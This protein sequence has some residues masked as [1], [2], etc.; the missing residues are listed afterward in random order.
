MG[1][2]HGPV[3]YPHHHHHQSPHP[4]GGGWWG[5]AMDYGVGRGGGG[6]GYNM[7]M[8]GY[9]M[10]YSEGF[11]GGYQRPGKRQ[12]GEGQASSGPSQYPWKDMMDNWSNNGQ[13]PAP[14]TAAGEKRMEVEGGNYAARAVGGEK[15]S[16]PYRLKHPEQP[17]LNY[18]VCSNYYDHGQ[19]YCK[20]YSLSQI[21]SSIS[22][23]YI[24]R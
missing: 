21:L 23:F 2:R 14:G 9:G 12:R 3:H 22:A 17:C 15:P 20:F 24:C 16:C 10:G 5:G 1:P 7:G 13:P 11:G 18:E 19:N 8:A 4:H 6:G